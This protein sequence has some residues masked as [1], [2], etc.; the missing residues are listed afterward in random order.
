M[1]A[2]KKEA[3]LFYGGD[4]ERLGKVIR[5]EREKAGL[6]AMRVA[7]HL[8]WEAQIIV[9]V[10]SGRAKSMSYDELLK[11][12]TLFKSS[13]LHAEAQF[14]LRECHEPLYCAA[15]VFREEDSRLTRHEWAFRYEMPL[16]TL[17]LY[18]YK[19][20]TRPQRNYGFRPSSQWFDRPKHVNDFKPTFIT[21]AEVPY[22]EEVE[23][24]AKEDFTKNILI[25]KQIGA[26]KP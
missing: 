7:E 17:C 9:E 8:R 16:N 4:L 10:E 23:K 12:A 26:I 24:F 14:L 20:T 18:W 5:T 13:E 1:D 11:L 19:R 22:D 3:P 25:C 2:N 15:K 21:L 6:I